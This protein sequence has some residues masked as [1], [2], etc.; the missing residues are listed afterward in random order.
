MCIIIPKAKDVSSTKIFVAPLINQRQVTVYS[1]KV[2]LDNPAA[3]ILP[4]PNKD[5]QGA[6]MVNL[7]NY[8]E[9]FEDLFES[10]QEHV[11]GFSNNGDGTRHRTRSL[12][13]IQVGSYSVSI[14]NNINDLQRLNQNVFKIE[15]EILDLF[16]KNYSNQFGFVV[17]IMNTGK[18]YH[19]IAYTHSRKNF[20]F[21]PTLHY[22]GHKETRPDWDHNI[23]VMNA[24]I[25]NLEYQERSFKS[26]PLNK[27]K[28]NV[29]TEPIKYM[30]KYR[31]NHGKVPENKDLI[32]VFV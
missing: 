1:N 23:Y 8:P 30:G 12:Q 10:F 6:K 31:I 32:G 27:D 21:V 13:V 28:W 18:K 3:M 7:E 16:K 14:A 26:L 11:L 4:Y 5:N 9:I 24:R 20:L 15:D 29:Q 19:P 2:D 22:H 17:C 25:A